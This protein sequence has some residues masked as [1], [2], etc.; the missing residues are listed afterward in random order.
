MIRRLLA[1]LLGA[2][3]LVSGGVASAA[4]KVGDP[5]PRIA[6]GKWAQGEPVKELEGDKVYIVEF[7][8]TWCGPCIAAIPHVNDLSKKYAADGLVVVGQNLGEDDKTVAAFVRKMGSKMSYRV[9]VDDVAGTMGKTWLKAAGQSGIPCAFVVNKKGKV[10]YIGHPMRLEESFIKKLLA[11]PGTK[12]A[13]EKAAV[14]QG[15]SDQ[16]KALAAR[17]EALL[18]AG[19]PDEAAPVVAELHEEL[20]DGCRHIGGLLEL[21]LMIARGELDDAAA[22]GGIL[23]EDFSGQPAVVLGVAQRL[24][25]AAKATPAMLETAD[26]LARPLASS[27]GAVKSGALAVQA[28]VAFR[29]GDAPRAVELQKQAVAAAAPDET[30]AAKQAQEAYEQGRLP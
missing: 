12:P 9:A 6:P 24:A 25:R 28:R 14:A 20:T 13:P 15:P 30:A 11:E 3:T 27:D 23:A 7:W 8:A 21:D 29:Q 22:L 17:A 18:A 10:A 5:A 4:L 26:G 16:A 19:K 1:C 2:G